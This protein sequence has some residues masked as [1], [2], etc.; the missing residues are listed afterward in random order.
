VGAPLFFTCNPQSN[1]MCSPEI[2]CGGRQSSH[3]A[4]ASERVCAVKLASNYA[5]RTVV[6]GPQMRGGVHFGEFHLSHGE[7]MY[8]G[9]CRPGFDPAAHDKA[10]HTS[11]GL[12]Y[13]TGDGN[14]WQDNSV[15]SQWEGREVRRAPS[16]RC[17]QLTLRGV[18]VRCS[19]LDVRCIMCTVHC[20][21]YDV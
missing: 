15:N 10:T 20:S 16:L 6:A 3:S 7:K 13:F 9:Y 19:L 11:D 17:T 2:F 8:V 12:A 14:I 1:S 5:W 4:V 21:L 18:C